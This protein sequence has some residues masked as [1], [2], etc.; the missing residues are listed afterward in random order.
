MTCMPSQS[1]LVLCLHE[2]L[3]GPVVVPSL[4]V[5]PRD[6]QGDILFPVTRPFHPVDLTTVSILCKTN[7]PAVPTPPGSRQ[8]ALLTKAWS[9]QTCLPRDRHK[10]PR[11]GPT[12]VCRLITF[13]QLSSSSPFRD[14]FPGRSRGRHR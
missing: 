5:V 3:P 6:H 14:C 1:P 11:P 10:A 9:L 7:H 13:F 12:H 4:S 2:H 8:S